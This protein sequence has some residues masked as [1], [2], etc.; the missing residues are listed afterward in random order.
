MFEDNTDNPKPSP[1]N[2]SA[3]TLKE[4]DIQ[5]NRCLFQLVPLEHHTDGT[6]SSSSPTDFLPTP[7][8]QDYNTGISQE[9]KKEKLKRYKEK[10]GPIPSGTYMLRQ[11]AIEGILP[12]PENMPEGLVADGTNNFRLNPLYI[13]EMMGF[14]SMYLAYPFLSQDGE[15]NP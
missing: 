6:E 8:M 5:S 15:K 2:E 13:E 12:A 7:Q 14:P 4:Q 10:G 3:V 11:M 9:A 1:S